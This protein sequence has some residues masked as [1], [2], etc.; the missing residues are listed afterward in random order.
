MYSYGNPNYSRLASHVL[1]GQCLKNSKIYFGP[2]YIDPRVSIFVIQP[3][4][5]GKSTPWGLIA[6]VAKEAGIAVDD[7]DEMTDAALI[8]TIEQEDIIDPETGTKKTTYNKVMGKLASAEL[9]HFDEGSMLLEKTQ[10]SGHAMTWFQKALNPL[11]SEQSK[12]TKKLAHGDQIEF[13]PTC[14]L[15]ITSHP[16][17]GVLETILNKGFF[18]RI[19]LYPRDVP[20]IER[21]NVEYQRAEKLGDRAFVEPDIKSMGLKLQAIRAK[22]KNKD[23]VFAKNTKPVIRARIQAFYDLIKDAHPRVKEIMATF[24][25]RYDNYMYILAFHHCADRNG[26]VVEIEDVKYAFSVLYL[27]FKDLITWVEETADFYKI[28]NKDMAY[29]RLAQQVFHK[30]N[31]DT[32]DGYVMKMSFIT[33]CAKSWK[34]SKVTVSKFIEKFKG[35]NRL[36]ELE[37][38]NIRYIKMGDITKEK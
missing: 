21:Q 17:E 2:L 11:D 22:W 10:H 20:I 33:Q 34:L 31:P 1:L 3:S 32:A 28:G 7:V 6:K 8:G 27:L 29:L 13:Y 35:Y 9:L 4:A 14:S 24:I 15:I 5:T 38:N 12:C 23:I 18:Q 25:P 19:I 37:L 26:D 36:K 30:M 16:L